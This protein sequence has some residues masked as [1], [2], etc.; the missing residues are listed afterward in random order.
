MVDWFPALSQRHNVTTWQGTEWI[1]DG[2]TRPQAVEIGS[3]REL[4]CVPDV[5]FVVLRP[6]CC[7][8]LA[9]E[10]ALVRTGVYRR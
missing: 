8:E 5:D 1:A 9:A 2:Y 7:E 4:A 10:L 6:G 3:C